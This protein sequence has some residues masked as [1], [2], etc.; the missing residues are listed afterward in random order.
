MRIF[1]IF[2]FSLLFLISV[3]LVALWWVICLPL[4]FWKTQKGAFTGYITHLPQEF[5]QII[6]AYDAYG[7][8]HNRQYLN[9]PETR[10]M[11]A[12][13]PIEKQ[14]EFVDLITVNSIDQLSKGAMADDEI[15]VSSLNSIDMTLINAT[16]IGNIAYWALHCN[17]SK[18]RMASHIALD[19]IK[20]HLGKFAQ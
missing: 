13:L 6:K 19:E 12:S 14:A 16:S 9:K 4:Q 7:L 17:N 15:I 18:I 20:N 2:V 3:I 11:V 5:R 1:S 8:R 10:N